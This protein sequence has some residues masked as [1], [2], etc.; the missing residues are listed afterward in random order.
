M[1]ETLPTMIQILGITIFLLGNTIRAANIT[2]SSFCERGASNRTETCNTNTGE[3]IYGCIVGFAGPNCSYEC[4]DTCIY[5]AENETGTC[6]HISGECL[7][8]C[9]DGF[10]G[11][12]CTQ[13]CYDI[14]PICER[15]IEKNEND[16]IECKK[17]NRNFYMSAGKCLSCNYWC[18]VVP[19]SAE[20]ICRP[21]DGYCNHGCRTGRYG[22][23]CGERCSSTCK[24]EC[25]R[26]TGT[27]F[28]CKYQSCCGPTCEIQCQD[29]CLLQQCNQ[30]CHCVNGCTTTHWGERCLTV[31]NYNCIKPADPSKRVCNTSDGTC[32]LGCE[33]ELFWG[34]QCN[35]V[36]PSYCVNDTCEQ[37]SG[38]CTEGCS[39]EAVY[40]WR[41]DTPCNK[42]CLGGT[43]ERPDGY[44]D[45][46]CNVGTYGIE[47]NLSC[48]ENCK[49]NT[50]NRQSGHC[51][52]GCKDGNYGNQ[53]ENTCSTTCLNQ[54]CDIV[55]GS[56][57]DGCI[58]GFEGHNY[59][60]ETK[61]VDNTLLG[62]TISGWSLLVIL[63]AFNIT[64]AL[65]KRCK[66]SKGNKINAKEDTQP[67]IRNQQ[68]Y[69]TLQHGQDE[70]HDTTKYE[71]LRFRE[72]NTTEQTMYENS[73]V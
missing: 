51:D 23:M 68:V 16:G 8:G 15:C 45:K 72:E 21:E 41:C 56:C 48:S 53:C 35:K 70:N 57:T 4:P 13:R 34:N 22:F 55:D 73:G 65:T 61:S 1:L 32:L 38:N 37:I 59:G 43:C 31:C 44:C 60:T 19:T 40:G 6:N 50:C 25:N 26:E 18:L 28:D 20:P 39:S 62:L 36:C 30:S 14:D 64:K 12:N 7:H 3:C 52:N 11:S 24:D 47:C 29:G 69:T 46:G 33:G 42:N 49:N 54:R 63:L 27:C 17:C 2:C 58:S 67:Q 71:V 5:P 10:Y 9:K 66:K